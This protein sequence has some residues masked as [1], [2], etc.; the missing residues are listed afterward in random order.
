MRKLSWFFLSF[1]VLLADQLTKGW[2]QD[3]LIPYQSYQLLPVANFTLAYNTGAAFSFLNS[4]GDWHRWFFA[5][6]T[7]IMSII[8][9]VWLV[10][11]SKQAILQ[12]LGLSLIL[13]GALGNLYDRLVLGHVI[14]FIDIFYKNYH[15]PAF[16]LADSAICA[17]TLCLVF[18]VCFSK[19][20]K[21]LA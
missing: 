16:N 6:F 19:K 3:H 13:G 20:S 17:G 9:G 21:L 12:A 11:L 10:R 2:A 8:L 1:I 15:W 14:D 4:A 18:D 5:G 7:L